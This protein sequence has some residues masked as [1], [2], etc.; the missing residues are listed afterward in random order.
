MTDTVADR[1]AALEAFERRHRLFEVLCDD[2]SVWRVLRRVV[3]RAL[4]TE[5]QP[6][7]AGGTGKPVRSGLPRALAQ[8]A[9]QMAMPERAD[10][11]LLT[12]TSALRDQ[13]GGKFRDIHFDDLL[14]RAYGV[15]DRAQK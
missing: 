11:V 5:R 13:A 4:T 2:W 10:L 12:A 7:A 3:H 1:L 9:R 8:F 6:A 14:H 15:Q